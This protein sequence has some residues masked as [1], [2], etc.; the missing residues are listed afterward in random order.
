MSIFNSAISLTKKIYNHFNTPPAVIELINYRFYVVSNI[1]QTIA[2][3]T[4][5]WW[6][7]MFYFLGATQLAFIQIPSILVYAVAI[8]VNRRGLHMLAMV[9][10]LSEIVA[11]QVLAVHY[12]GGM[13]IFNTLY[14]L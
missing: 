1:A 7:I 5:F 10:S 9:I 4:H 6:M 11:H 14:Q 3:A 12:V 13:Q 2:W 8:M